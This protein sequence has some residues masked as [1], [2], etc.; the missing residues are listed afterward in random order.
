MNVEPKTR[1]R[2]FTLIE[3]IIVV[4][5]LVLIALLLMP[6]M[7]GNKARPERIECVNNLKQVGLAFN[8]WAQDHS[9][10]L[11][12]Q[13]S[14]TNGGA[15]EP[16]L[17]GAIF[18]SF[19]VMSNELNTPKILWCPA[20]KSPKAAKSFAQGLANSNINYFVGLDTKPTAPNMFLSGDDN[21]MVGG[22]A[23]GGMVIG[24]TAVKPG[25][26]SLWTNT[27]TKWTEDR[28]KKQGNVGLAD[29]SV[30]GFSTSKLREALCGTG[31]VTNRLAFP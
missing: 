13:E 8:Q 4:A 27:P 19:L 9:A 16:T 29:G 28:H 7:N 2:G 5:V 1:R 21:L 17:S 24:G 20:G 3:F 23:K 6:R 15:M 25:I 22:E 31:E 11:P 30:Q 26:L 14:V 10:R 12:M 18:A